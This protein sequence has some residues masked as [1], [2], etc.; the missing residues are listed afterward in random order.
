MNKRL[1]SKCYN[2]MATWCYLPDDTYY[3]DDCVPRGCNCRLHEI[4]D[5]ITPKSNQR[6][7]YWDETMTTSTKEKQPNQRFFEYVDEKWRRYPCCEFIF[8]E[9]GFDV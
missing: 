8:D 2:K 4:T 9:I 7:L 1:C 5:N 3:C 6:V